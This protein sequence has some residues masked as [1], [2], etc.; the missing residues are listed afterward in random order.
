MDT[1]PDGWVIDRT[2]GSPLS[3]YVFITNGK[4][5]LNGQ[6]RALLN[7]CD[8]LPSLRRTEQLNFDIFFEQ[9]KTT[10]VGN[11]VKKKQNT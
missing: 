11:F 2:A 1:L 8:S 4:S 9:S 7:I 10:D 6:Q 5:V 3:G